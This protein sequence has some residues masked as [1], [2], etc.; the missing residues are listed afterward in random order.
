MCAKGAALVVMIGS[1]NF[2]FFK[3]F[4]FFIIFL[5]AAAAS[6]YGPLYDK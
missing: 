4:L 5:Y 1:M 6:V 2:L 3:L